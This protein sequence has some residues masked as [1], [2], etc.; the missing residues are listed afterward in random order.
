[1]EQKKLLRSNDRVIAGVCGGIA[2]Y[3][4]ID[5]TVVRVAYVVLTLFTVFCGIILYPILW[6]IMPEK[7]MY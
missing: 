1:M 3:L 5:P 4:N 2:E 6:I 7:R